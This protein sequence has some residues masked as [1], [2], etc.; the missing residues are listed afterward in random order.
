MHQVHL[1]AGAEESS[2]GNKVRQVLPST[3]PHPRYHSTLYCYWKRCHFLNTE[4]TGQ[5]YCDILIADV[6]K[7]MKKLI[8]NEKQPG[9]K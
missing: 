7:Y 8:E 4:N 3:V 1:H 9:K 5:I 6:N 2:V